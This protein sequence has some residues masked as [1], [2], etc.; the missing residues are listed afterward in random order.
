VRVV[1]DTNIL[2]SACWTPSG[3]EAA[4]LQ[5]VLDGKITACVSAPVWAEYNDVLFRDKFAVL[6]GRAGEVLSALKVL[7]LTVEPLETLNISSDDDDNRLLECAAAAGADYLV[8][9]NLRHFPAECGCVRVVNARQ[10]L[11][12]SQR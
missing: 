3:L 9:G 12:F 1:L 11:S 5:S 6:H 7:A 4:V 8:T 10:F 2:I